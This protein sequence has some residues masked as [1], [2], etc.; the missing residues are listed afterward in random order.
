MNV[1][2]LFSHISNRV[3]I[4]VRTMKRLFLYLSA[5]VVAVLSFSSCSKD[6]AYWKVE[7]GEIMYYDYS[8]FERFASEIN[9]LDDGVTWTVYQ[10]QREVDKIV[11]KYDGELGGK[12]YLK[13]GSSMSGPWTTKK[14]WTMRLD[15]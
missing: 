10:V 14:T 11:D 9:A 4:I 8:D 1:C 2:G 13:T 15:R 3:I 5:I 7:T 12:V 6:E